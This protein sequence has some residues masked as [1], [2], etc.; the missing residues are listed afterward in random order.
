MVP[1]HYNGNWQSS[2]VIHIA[3]TSLHRPG[4]E[5]ALLV[6]STQ[7]PRYSIGGMTD[8]LL[9]QRYVVTVLVVFSIPI[10]W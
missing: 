4:V 10:H 3:V 5:C 6:S 9:T 7:L 2:E 1:N 8:S